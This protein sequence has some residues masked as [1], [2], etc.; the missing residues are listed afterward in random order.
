MSVSKKNGVFTI[1]DN[2][3]G[4]EAIK[5]QHLEHVANLCRK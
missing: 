4:G 3:L 5:D 2:R 1:I